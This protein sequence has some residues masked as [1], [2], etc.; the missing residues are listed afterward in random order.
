M[1]FM[2]SRAYHPDLGARGQPEVRPLEFTKD[3][4]KQVGDLE[5]AGYK[6]VHVPFPYCDAT[7]NAHLVVIAEEG[8]DLEAAFEFS[9]SF[10]Y[11]AAARGYRFYFPPKLVP[12]ETSKSS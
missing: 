12:L 11:H 6:V 8:V 3:M 9:K 5:A 2:V 7:S 1:R 4:E 10:E